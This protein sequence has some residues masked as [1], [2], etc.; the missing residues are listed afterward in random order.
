MVPGFE[1]EIVC[2]LLLSLNGESVIESEHKKELSREIEYI[3][4]TIFES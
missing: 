2:L 4:S 1:N 3:R